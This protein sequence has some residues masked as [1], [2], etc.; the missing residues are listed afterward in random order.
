MNPL[1]KTRAAIAAYDAAKFSKR[2]ADVTNADAAHLLI[3]EEDALLDRINAAYL[4]DT[5]YKS[6]T[7]PDAFALE[8]MRRL[9]ALADKAAKAGLRF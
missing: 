4:E 5:G 3:A 6:R 8:I 2:W 9:L 7:R 1:T